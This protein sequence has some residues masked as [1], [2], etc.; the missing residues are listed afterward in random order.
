M[1]RLVHQ[2]QVTLDP[3][4]FLLQLSLFPFSPLYHLVFFLNGLG[5][6]LLSLSGLI[7]PLSFSLH[8][9]SPSPFL[10]SYIY[11][12]AESPDEQYQILSSARKHFAAGGPL[13]IPYTLPPLVFQVNISIISILCIETQ[14]KQML[15]Q[16][17]GNVTPLPF[18]EIL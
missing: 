2:L 9:F 6:L 16:E 3:S 7:V 5:S 14:W 4:H 1:G 18:Y 13:R 11:A 8:F 17:H 12:Q 15:P 10:P